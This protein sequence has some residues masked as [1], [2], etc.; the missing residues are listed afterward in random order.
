MRFSTLAFFGISGIVC[1]FP[2]KA[3]DYL[4]PSSS[5]R[6][7]QQS[8]GPAFKGHDTR[9][10]AKRLDAIALAKD[11]FE[12]R[13]DFERRVRLAVAASTAVNAGLLCVLPVEGWRHGVEYDAD[14]K[15]LWIPIEE[16]FSALPS[17]SGDSLKVI[18]SAIWNE[19]TWTEPMANAFGVQVKVTSKI[20]ESA[21]IGFEYDSL[22]TWMLKNLP[23]HQFSGSSVSAKAVSLPMAP[24][25]ARSKI[26][27]VKL[28][29]Q[30]E[31]AQPYRINDS[32][33][34]LA[35]IDLPVRSAEQQTIVVGT[36]KAIGVFDDRTGYILKLI[37]VDENKAK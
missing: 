29:F 25:D 11:Q 34:V 2:L 17:R 6:L 16:V 1:P 15:I 14:A 8:L 27:H 31:L 5:C 33:G 22:S 10:I 3:Q 30:Y 37:P 18:T 35:T 36:L 4:S 9:E 20:S 21:G 7:D 32:T 28:V 12:T 13:A 23:Y 24:D 19:K 26:D